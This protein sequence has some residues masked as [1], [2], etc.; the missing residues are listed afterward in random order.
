MWKESSSTLTNLNSNL[1]PCS[2][3]FYGKVIHILL[4]HFM[5]GTFLLSDVDLKKAAKQF[6]QK[7]SCGS[8]VTG[9]DEIVIQGDITDDIFDFLQEKWP[10][11]S[12]GSYG[13]CVKSTIFEKD[14]AL[15][16]RDLSRHACCCK[17]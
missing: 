9:D 10:Q 14:F 1:H 3:C 11:V 12:Y 17:A 7:F 2:E 13:V 15:P 16:C 8:S 5:K 4:L 6:A